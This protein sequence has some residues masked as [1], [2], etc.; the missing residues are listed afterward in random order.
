[1]ARA[2]RPHIASED[3]ELGDQNPWTKPTGKTLS[4]LTS[5]VSTI[6]K[7]GNSLQ[8]EGS[9]CWEATSITTTKLNHKKRSDTACSST[10]HLVTSAESILLQHIWFHQ[11]PT[12]VQKV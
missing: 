1:M 2:K 5:W 3:A 4:T 9:T 7:L 11:S 12:I 10:A 6:N 8:N